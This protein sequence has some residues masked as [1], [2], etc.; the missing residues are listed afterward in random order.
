MIMSNI[1]TVEMSYR[2]DVI[3]TEREIVRLKML[4]CLEEHSD[5][6]MDGVITGVQEYGFIVQIDEFQLDGLVHIRTLKDDSYGLS[7]KNFPW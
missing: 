2:K 7:K 1:S 4:R 5:K 6:V 3:N